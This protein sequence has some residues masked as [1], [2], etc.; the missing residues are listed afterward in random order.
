MTILTSTVWV[1]NLN[2]ESRKANSNYSNRTDFDSNAPLICEVAE[3]VILDDDSILHLILWE[4]SIRCLD[5][6]LK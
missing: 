4:K 1:N 5:I 6:G 2:A 3:H